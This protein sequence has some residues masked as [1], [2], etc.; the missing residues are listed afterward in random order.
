MDKL[1]IQELYKQ[2]NIVIPLIEQS[3]ATRPTNMLALIKKRYYHAK[4]LIESTPFEDLKK[5]S[6]SI[7]G[8][9]KAYLDSASDYMNPMLGEMNKAEQVFKDA[10]K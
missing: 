7:S 6:F 1:K 9:I 4:K 5:E 3:Y 8:G 10:F 2:I